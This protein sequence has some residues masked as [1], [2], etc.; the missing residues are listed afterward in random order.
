LYLSD[1]R[2]KDDLTF[3][4]RFD[5]PR[6]MHQL[7][8]TKY[9]FQSLGAAELAKLAFMEKFRT[10]G[11]LPDWAE[12]FKDEKVD[13]RPY[14]FRELKHPVLESLLCKLVALTG[15]RRSLVQ[16]TSCR[17]LDCVLKLFTEPP[18]GEEKRR[19][20]RKVPS[21][22]DVI[23]LVLDGGCLANLC[24]VLAKESTSLRT[25]ASTLIMTIVSVLPHA[26]TFAG[27][28]EAQ[29]GTLNAVIA[30]E[31]TKLQQTHEEKEKVLS[32]LNTAWLT[33][34]QTIQEQQTSAHIS[35]DDAEPGASAQTSP[36]ED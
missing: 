3:F 36:A 27:L 19:S 31:R 15:H 30:R 12:P 5:I 1:Q 23:Q 17:A 24:G 21:P 34:E 16:L 18:S 2:D 20:E 4:V 7:D 22:R 26:S 32:L 25:A 14:S 13:G 29:L 33:V 6:I 9:Q 8:D 35:D 28:S 11:T 10:N